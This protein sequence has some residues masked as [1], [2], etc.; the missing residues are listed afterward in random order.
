MTGSQVKNFES[1]PYENLADPELAG[2]PGP[3]V[4]ELIDRLSRLTRELQYVDGLNPA[5]WEA[6]RF[7]SRANRYSRTPGAVA[8]F[9]G[10]TKGTISQTITALENKGLLERRPSNRDKRVCL[11]DLTEKGKAL[12]TRDPVRRIEQ[13]VG[14]MDGPTGAAMVQGLSRLLAAVQADADAPLFGVCVACCRHLSP[15]EGCGKGEVGRCGVTGEALD[16][17]DA[18]RICVNYKNPE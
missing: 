3:R 10:C 9:L 18:A 5:Q 4:A 12:I 13:A 16:S 17:D 1:K 7:L 11:I 6:L 2:G 15:N 8:Q 14:A